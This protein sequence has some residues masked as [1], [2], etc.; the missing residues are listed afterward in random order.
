[1]PIRGPDR[2]PIVG[3]NAADECPL[4]GEDRKTYAHFEDYR[5]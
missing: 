1:M 4:S 5:S 3:T 2:M